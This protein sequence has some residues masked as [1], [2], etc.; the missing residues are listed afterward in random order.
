MGKH[1]VL[2]SGQIGS[3]VAAALA[4]RGEEVL[5]VRRSARDVGIAGVGV[6]RGDLGDLAF[7]R[8]LGRGADVVY[9]CT[10]PA[11]H[12]WA[13]ELLPNAEGAIAIASASGARLVVLDNLY[14]YGDTGAAPR[15][16]D[17]PMAPCSRKG[18][19]RRTMAERYR[20][21]ADAGLAVSLV[22]ASDFVGPELDSAVLGDRAV[23]RLLAG[24]SVE[25][26]GD[27][28]QPHAY[29]YAPDVAEALLR[30]AS[31][32]AM[33]FVVH[34]PT[35]PARSTRAWVEAIASA[36]GV[37]PKTMR[38]PSWLLR[39][40]GLFDPAMGELVEMLYQFERP[41]LLDDR[42]SR[43]T[44]A[45]EATPFERQIAS[46]VAPARVARAA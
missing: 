1:I 5:V 39:A 36:L 22:R 40:M 44:L 17:A 9:Q 2:G 15:S 25:V 4:A 35:L 45:M 29:T 43:A 20:S 6:R 26:L 34:V 7:A 24:K 32:R 42:R 10:N 33:P 27:P 31:L 19:L 30:A 38:A 28:D 23:S 14:A 21:A 13:R 18:E 16:E 3:R 37:A 41:F 46:I 12:Q 11:Y 8:S